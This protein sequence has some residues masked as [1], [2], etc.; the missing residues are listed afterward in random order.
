VSGDVTVGIN[1]CATVDCG[2]SS[3]KI[4]LSGGLPNVSAVSAHSTSGDITM[5][6]TGEASQYSYEL[7]S[8]SGDLSI[9]ANGQKSHGEKNLSGTSDSGNTITAK[10]TS[11]DIKVIFSK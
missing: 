2:T 11:G 1:G 4:K 10:S 8:V 9:D 6:M 7:T 3:G 5:N